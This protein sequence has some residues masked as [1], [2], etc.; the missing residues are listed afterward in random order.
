V[1]TFQALYELALVMLHVSQIHDIF[2]A[3][4]D[5]KEAVADLYCDIVA[6][7]GNITVFYRNE[8]SK[9]AAGKTVTLN[10]E[11]V[12]GEDVSNI[13]KRQTTITS[14]MWSLKLGGRNGSISLDSLRRLLKHDRSVKGALYDQVTE[15]MKRAEGTCEWVKEPLI[16][17]FRGRDKALTIT[18]DS[19]TGKTVLAGWIKE[20][21]QRP[22]NH[23]QYLALIYS[24]RK[25]SSIQPAFP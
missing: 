20:R 9:L 1:P 3:S 19:G 11:A 13:Y 8:I 25:Y 24:F 18:G 4:R 15:S 23:T 12:F 22:L 10:F 21:L 6:L 5:V 16:E 2:Q 14:R 7:I 17:F